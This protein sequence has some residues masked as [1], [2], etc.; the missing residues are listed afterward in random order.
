MQAICQGQSTRS[1]CGS[2]GLCV[3]SVACFLR[4]VHSETVLTASLQIDGIVQMLFD[5]VHHHSY[6]GLMEV[7]QLLESKFFSSPAAVG[8]HATVSQL[9]DALKRSY[10]IS[11]IKSN[12]PELKKE[13]FAFLE[14]HAAELQNQSDWTAWFG[15]L[16]AKSPISSN[17]IDC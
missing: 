2:S 12:N 15:K 10:L 11:L 17:Q 14:S 4:F 1:S 5:S 6:T 16:S 9:E 3:F 8:F 7:W 13:V